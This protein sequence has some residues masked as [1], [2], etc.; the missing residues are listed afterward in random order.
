MTLKTDRTATSIFGI[1]PPT[2]QHTVSGP[3]PPHRNS[4]PQTTMAKNSGVPNA[5]DDDWEAQADKAAAKE[6]TLQTKQLLTK[7]GAAGPSKGTAAAAEEGAAEMTR[8]E[9]LAKHEENNRRLWN[10]A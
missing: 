8:A 7:S 2:L 4:F 5:W 6:K 1:Q 10:S 9:R 3:L